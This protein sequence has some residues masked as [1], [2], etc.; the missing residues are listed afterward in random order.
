MGFK[1]RIEIDPD[2]NEEIIIRC[3]G[4]TDRVI[5]LQKLLESGG[6][7]QQEMELHL[8]GN[9]YFVKLTDI[10]FFETD[11]SKTAAHTK[12]KM[13]YTDLKLYELEDTLPRSFMRVSKSCIININAIS[14][15]KRELTG[16][17]EA[18]FYDSVKKVYISRSYF[19]LFREALNDIRLK[20]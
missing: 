5:Q 4:I 13:Y 10:L 16:I 17:G 9:D 15:T 8:N 11:D 3:R 12:N 2:G 18:C 19:K 20:K 14:S 1:T 7:A 6:S